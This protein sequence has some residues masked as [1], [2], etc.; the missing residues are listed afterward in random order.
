MSLPPKSTATPR[1]NTSRAKSPAAATSSSSSGGGPPGLS[2]SGNRSR[3]GTTTPT[4]RQG[5]TVQKDFKVVRPDT[6]SQGSLYLREPPPDPNER[7]KTAAPVQPPPAARSRSRSGTS[8]ANAPPRPNRPPRAAKPSINTTGSARPVVRPNLL[9][10]HT[11]QKEIVIVTSRGTFIVKAGVESTI[12]WALEVASDLMMAANPLGAADEGTR[13]VLVAARTGSGAI[14]GEEELVFDVCKEDKILFAIT[15]DETTNIP[16]SFAHAFAAAPITPEERQ[17]S[18]R[19]ARRDSA[20]SGSAAPTHAAG[21]MAT[22]PG[23]SGG[24][25]THI[26][27]KSGM[28]RFSSRI[29]MSVAMTGYV[30]DLDAMVSQLE[31]KAAE[32]EAEAIAV[33]EEVARRREEE[34]ALDEVRMLEENEGKEVAA[35]TVLNPFG[36]DTDVV[37][38]VDG[39]EVSGVSSIGGDDKY[40]APKAAPTVSAEEKL[41][42]RLTRASALSILMDILPPMP[43]MPAFTARPARASL[44]DSPTMPR[45]TLQIA[46]P[47]DSDE[48]YQPPVSVTS[49][50]SPSSPA[51]PSILPGGSKTASPISSI[52][53][54]GLRK[55]SFVVVN[56]EDDE[57]EVKAKEPPKP[58]MPP[59]PPVVMPVAIAMAKVDFGEE[60]EE[61]TYVAPEPITLT[62]APGNRKSLQ[63][64]D[65]IPGW[66]L[67]E[68][69]AAAAASIPTPV[70][71]PSMPEYAQEVALPSVSA[72]V[73]PDAAPAAEPASVEPTE[74]V[75]VTP[76]PPPMVKTS[77][78]PPPPPPPPVFA[79][80][81]PPPPPPPVISGGPPPPPPPPPVMGTWF[82]PGINTRLGFDSTI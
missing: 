70:A 27:R 13:V 66:M 38:V 33:Q 4:S 77:S 36:Q 23:S 41:S 8:A 26:K 43:T 79:A 1:V 55:S 42:R 52:P 59:I 15:A 40:A 7:K 63:K 22:S 62:A 76:P 19:L 30:D 46:N 51:I 69:Q 28:D 12:D 37:V 35:V 60:V 17:R 73:G 21:T 47:D 57:A 50:R 82:P 71:S 80:P 58:I 2:R 49:S 20:G 31:S 32:A 14:A 44:G 48:E 11:L 16:P 78:I 72:P 3:T 39:D 45:K 75:S 61:A 54:P 24:A 10:P 74:A 81:P 67:E 34:P 6:F 56:P 9:S 68:Q 29:R 53:L 18:S 25:A 5:V 64:E 65:A